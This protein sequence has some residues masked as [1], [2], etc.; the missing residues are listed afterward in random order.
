[1]TA[2]YHQLCKPPNTCKYS[3]SAIDYNNYIDSYDL[4]GN[5]TLNSL[6]YLFYLQYWLKS[7]NETLSK[8]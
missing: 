7:R 5:L 1:M 3:L 4:G 2:L 6:N 8:R